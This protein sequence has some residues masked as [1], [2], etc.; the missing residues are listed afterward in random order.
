[1]AWYIPKADITFNNKHLT[2]SV[3]QKNSDG[4]GC[5]AGF[6]D[7]HVPT[8]RARIFYFS[9]RKDTASFTKW[10]RIGHSRRTLTTYPKRRFILKAQHSHLPHHLV[11]S[12]ICGLALTFLLIPTL[13]FAGPGGYG[14]YSAQFKI[15][16]YFDSCIDLKGRKTANGN[17]T[18]QW[19]CKRDLIPK[20]N[21]LWRIDRGPGGNKVL[22]RNEKKLSSCLHATKGRLWVNLSKC[23][24][25]HDWG[26][27]WAMRRIG[28]SRRGTPYVQFESLRHRGLCLDL[29][30]DGNKAPTGNNGVATVVA[31]CRPPHRARTQRFELYVPKYNRIRASFMR[32]A[33]QLKDKTVDRAVGIANKEFKKM[34]KFT[35]SAA[36]K[37][38][39]EA[40]KAA[41]FM[42]NFK[43][44][45]LKKQAK[46]IAKKAL[47]GVKGKLKKAVFKLLEKA[48]SKV[49][50]KLKDKLIEK[51]TPRLDKIMSKARRSRLGKRFERKIKRQAKKRIGKLIKKMIKKAAFQSGKSNAATVVA[52]LIAEQLE[53]IVNTL[54]KKTLDCLKKGRKGKKLKVCLAYNWSEVPFDYVY[55]GGLQLSSQAIMYTVGLPMIATCQTVVSIAIPG[56]GLALGFFACP[57]AFS[58]VLQEAAKKHIKND[59]KRALWS[60][61]GKLGFK[62]HNALRTKLFKLPYSN[63]YFKNEEAAQKGVS[64]G[65]GH[66]SN[67]RASGSLRNES[68]YVGCYLDEGG[69]KRRLPK[70]IG[71]KYTPSSCKNSCKGKGYRYAGLQYGG[72]CYCGNRIH[73][74][75]RRNESDCNKVCNRQKGVKCGGSWRNSVY[76]VGATPRATAGAAAGMYRICNLW[77][78]SKCIHIERGRIQASKIQQRWSSAKWRLKPIGSSFQI[79]NVWKPSECIHI[80]RGRIQASGIR[81]SWGS[82]RWKFKKIINAYRLCNEWKSSKCIHIEKG[83]IQASDAKNGWHSARWV[84]KRTR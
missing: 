55:E 68:G 60:G 35:K 27:V 39:A 1:M 84:L 64:G 83:R 12:M 59:I 61:K 3:K 2:S 24:H 17:P 52:T 71:D 30:R 25:R 16:T 36:N 8:L 72:Q 23:Y 56:P 37:M 73:S 7:S 38:K 34:K 28:T 32:F 65:N 29:W 78:P 43:D 76:R 54:T 11:L 21:K 82:A 51:L 53:T 19:K 40:Q 15:L 47:K 70:K 63:K 20:S 22:I 5:I 77:K 26:T 18:H 10:W 66:R 42:K 50:G 75:D 33:D 6:A 13:T 48:L 58:M 67:K 41:K 46:E 44:E 31:H 57:S 69:K 4:S 80:E 9:T 81:K 74:R 49:Y 62:M 79:C 45:Y 14:N